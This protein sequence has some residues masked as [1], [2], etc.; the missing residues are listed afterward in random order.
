MHQEDSQS[1]VSEMKLRIAFLHNRDLQI[2]REAYE[3]TESKEK[4]PQTHI[5]T[6]YN[7]IACAEAVQMLDSLLKLIDT[8]QTAYKSKTYKFCS[9]S[10]S[11]QDYQAL[12]CTYTC[13]STQLKHT[14]QEDGLRCHRGEGGIVTTYILW[15][16]H[17]SFVF[18]LEVLYRVL[19]PEM[20]NN[21]LQ[22]KKCVGPAYMGMDLVW[23]PG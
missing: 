19:Y 6:L 5:S 23:V 2:S 3:Q 22:K 21:S 14:L 10:Y 12:Q 20:H 15:L 7:A 8:T 11:P 9:G 18:F 13:P 4:A 16:S 17:I 1:Q